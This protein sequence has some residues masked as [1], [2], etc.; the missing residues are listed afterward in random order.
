MEG[1]WSEGLPRRS[2]RR[3]V[4]RSRRERTLAKITL[5]EIDF[6]FT[7]VGGM[8][9]NAKDREKEV[10][11][12]YK[13]ARGRD[14]RTSPHRGS[15]RTLH[16]QVQGRQGTRSQR[17]SR[18]AAQRGPAGALGRLPFEPSRTCRRSSPAWYYNANVLNATEHERE[19]GDHRPTRGS[20]SRHDSTTNMAGRGRRTSRSTR[21]TQLGG[22]YVLGTSG[23]SRASTHQM[24]GVR[25]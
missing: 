1:P 2:R 24:R 7:D 6:R 14:P 4:S 13:P 9:G 10:V 12:I 20:R 8:T 25:A 16:L 3:R 18:R 17:D 5:S 15:T 11:E 19:D 22:L 23:R 21:G